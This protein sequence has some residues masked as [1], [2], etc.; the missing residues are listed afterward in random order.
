M[1]NEVINLVQDF[2][3]GKEKR[4]YLYLR[5]VGAFFVGKSKDG[6]II[7]YLDKN[8]RAAPDDH[9]TVLLD[10]NSKK[11][12]GLHRTIADNT[13]IVQMKMNPNYIFNQEGSKKLMTE[14]QQ[15]K[16]I[17]LLIKIIIPLI[18]RTMNFFFIK[19][20][21]DIRKFQIIRKGSKGYSNTWVITD[22]PN[23][24]KPLIVFIIQTWKHINH[25]QINYSLSQ[26][27]K[28]K[29]IPGYKIKKHEI[30]NL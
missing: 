9:V 15:E 7:G 18:Y 22:P 21:G 1:Q 19:G 30:K 4:F 16:N 8:L 27:F 6:F 17:S 12:I 5:G 25:L 24:I 26:K 20:S 13:M 10:K 2:I 29:D 14:L 11:V 3:D 28:L 23:Y